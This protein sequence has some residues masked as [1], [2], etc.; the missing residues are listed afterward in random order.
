MC[1]LA[2]DMLVHEHLHFL[3]DSPDP[4]PH[5]FLKSKDLRRTPKDVRKAPNYLLAILNSTYAKQ[6]L[7]PP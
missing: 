5:L 2:A 3:L 4:L 1:T 6:L 7:T